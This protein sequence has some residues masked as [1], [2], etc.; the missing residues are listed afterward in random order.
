MSNRRTSAE[1]K[2][3]DFRLMHRAELHTVQERL[4]LPG[5]WAAAGSAPDDRVPANVAVLGLRV[6]PGTPRKRSSA[7][8]GRVQEETGRRPHARVTYR[9]EWRL[10]ALWSKGRGESCGCRLSCPI[11]HRVIRGTPDHA[12][13]R[14]ESPTAKP[15]LVVHD[16]DRARVLWVGQG[17]GR[18]DRF[19]NDWFESPGCDMSPAY[20]GA[21]TPLSACDAGH[22]P[23]PS[24][25]S[26]EPGRGRGPQGTVAGPRHAGAEGDQRA[27]VAAQHEVPLE[28]SDQGTHPLPQ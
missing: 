23:L 19:F 12:R 22:R 15:T 13:G 9:L 4:S 8:H 16:L 5:V 10:C 28:P 27:A 1:L 7:R 3:T 20:I 2:I 21:I 25:Q 17:K 24:R 6:V 26:A 11:L 14:R 18:V